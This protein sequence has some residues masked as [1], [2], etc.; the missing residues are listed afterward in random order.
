MR[1]FLAANLFHGRSSENNSEFREESVICDQ[2]SSALTLQGA[3]KGGWQK[4]FYHLFFV[5][6]TLSVTFSDAPVTFS[7]LFPPFAGLL[8]RQCENLCLHWKYHVVGN[9]YLKCSWECYVQTNMHNICLYCGQPKY[10]REFFCC[11]LGRTNWERITQHIP[12]CGGPRILQIKTA[13]HIQDI[14][15]PPNKSCM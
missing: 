10:F 7:S 3:A 4:E 15:A 8:L 6:G 1:L 5:F 9:Y 14:P 2:G 13:L 12:I 11:L